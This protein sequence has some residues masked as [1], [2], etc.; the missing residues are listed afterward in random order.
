MST[1]V[2]KVKATKTKKCEECKKQL[3]ETEMNQYCNSCG[4]FYCTK[5][6]DLPCPPEDVD[7]CDANPEETHRFFS[8]KP[9]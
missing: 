7:D 3:D 2:Q 9:E 6:F 8:S 5:C 1:I 4:N